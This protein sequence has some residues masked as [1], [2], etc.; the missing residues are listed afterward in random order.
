MKMAKGTGYN[1]KHLLLFCL[2]SLKLSENVLTQTLIVLLAN[3]IDAKIETPH[4]TAGA[5]LKTMGL[6]D[7][8]GMSKSSTC[9][10]S[11]IVA[12]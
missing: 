11:T 9:A 10:L 8:A 6:V 3:N 2:H 5:R 12:C 7:V 1:K 4:T